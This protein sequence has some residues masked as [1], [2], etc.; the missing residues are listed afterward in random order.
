MTIP[1]PFD[2]LSFDDVPPVVPN[3]HASVPL[4][5]IADPFEKPKEPTRTGGILKAMTGRTKEHKSTRTTGRARTSPPP[6]NR[7]GQFVQPIEEFYTFLGIAAM[8]FKPA[9]A[10]TLLSPPPGVEDPTAPTVAH[11]CAVAWD[12]VAQKNEAV[13]R[14]LKTFTTVSVWGALITA[15]VPI[16]MAAIDGTDL[17]KRFNPATGA[18]D[19][20]KSQGESAGE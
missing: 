2:N 1:D 5:A 6:E 15:H 17:A 10:M 13:R 16:L 3:H 4:D 8:P 9:V 18:E 20:L 11:N 12:E 14:A 19:F 7:P